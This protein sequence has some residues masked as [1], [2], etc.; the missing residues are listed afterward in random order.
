M[1]SFFL[2]IENLQHIKEL[3]FLIDV[4]KSGLMV[5]VGKNG[6]GKTM[7]FKA[8]Q[9]LVTSN[10]FATT[11]NTHIYQENSRISYSIRNFTI[12]LINMSI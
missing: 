8:I 9:N 1:N 6:V 12:F 10:T 7:L 2:K 5:I 11:S 3:E 4:S